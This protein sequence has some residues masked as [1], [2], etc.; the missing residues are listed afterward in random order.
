MM[1][2]ASSLWSKRFWMGVA[3]GIWLSGLLLFWALIWPALRL[4]ITTLF[5]GYFLGWGAALVLASPLR[6]RAMAHF[7]VTTL[8]LAISLGVLELVSV[9]GLIDFRAVLATTV[10][11]PCN[12]ADNVRDP[13]LIH[14]HKPYLKRVG[15]TRGD[16]ALAL[17]LASTRLY[18]Y[19]VTCDRNGFR[20]ACDLSA[21]EVVVLGDSFVEGGLTSANDLMTAT[22]GRLLRRTVANLGQ[23]AYGPQQELAVLRRYAASLRPRLCI[24]TFYEGND[25]YDVERYE[26]LSQGNGQAAARSTPQ[27]RSFARNALWMLAE[28]LGRFLAPDPGDR[29]PQGTFQSED[30]RKVQLFFHNRGAQRCHRELAALDKVLSVLSAAN[31]ACV[32]NRISLLVVFAPEKFRVYR[33]YCTFRPDNPCAGWVIDDLPEKLGARLAALSPSI[34]FLDLTPALMAEAAQGRLLYFTDDTHWSAEGHEIAGRTIATHVIHQSYL[35]LP[36]EQLRA[37]ED[38]PVSRQMSSRGAL[39]NEE[40]HAEASDAASSSCRIFLK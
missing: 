26:Q 22:L 30:G 38:W 14:I 18:P 31:A 10:P 25:L 28:R 12:N 19:A 13:E 8:T 36:S 39:G 3:A 20:N 24:W 11:D 2:Q 23:S 27:Q 33:D 17:H 29:A 32:A 21:A 35:D 16:I 7:T 6:R 40:R 9:V 1:A 15:A 34:G 37:G 5:S 4:L